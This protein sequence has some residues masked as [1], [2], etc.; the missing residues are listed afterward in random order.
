[1]VTQQ[2]A[3]TLVR[4]RN[5]FERL[6]AHLGVLLIPIQHNATGP[7]QIVTTE[8]L[9]ADVIRKAA[10]DIYRK[11]QCRGMES[12][13]QLFP[14]LDAL[15]NL[16]FRA[17]QSDTTDQTTI[18]F[19]ELLGQATLSILGSQSASVSEPDHR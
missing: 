6:E 11:N 18:D 9:H 10:V 4:Y 16:R 5:Y 12:P 3:T 19:L 2:K 7:R 15:G 8:A 17:E 13:I 1:M 14:T